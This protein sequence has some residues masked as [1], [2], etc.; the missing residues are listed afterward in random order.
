MDTFLKK[1]PS[2]VHTVRFILPLVDL[3]SGTSHDEQQLSD[4]AK[5]ILRSRFGKSK[6][7]PSGVDV[8]QV[9]ETSKSLHARARKSHSSDILATLS[10]SSIYLSRILVH[11]DAGPV[12]LDMYRESLADF[13]TR[14]NSALNTAYFQDFLRRFPTLG[15][16]LREDF[17]DLSGRAVNA[18]RQSQALHLLEIIVTHVPVMVCDLS[19]RGTRG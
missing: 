6:E 16:Q 8:E 13:M 11:E 19:F 15:W 12:V 14:K 10:L 17:L 1:Q 2:N 18:Y 7:V 9:T 3:I 5:G 4:K